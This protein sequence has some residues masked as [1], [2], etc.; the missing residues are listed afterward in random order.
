[1]DLM[2]SRTV[3]EALRVPAV[4]VGQDLRAV[5]ASPRWREAY[6]DAFTPFLAEPLSTIPGAFATARGVI[7]T[8]LEAQVVVSE[9]DLLSEVDHFE[10]RPVLARGHGRLAI[11][12]GLLVIGV[13]RAK[14][15]R[16]SILP[17]AE[18]ASEEPPE[19]TSA[20]PATV[21]HRLRTD[22]QDLVEHLGVLQASPLSRPQ[23]ERVD[24]A[25]EKALGLVAYL[26]QIEWA[27]ML[28]EAPAP[29]PAP[30][31]P[32]ARALRALVV[33]DNSINRHVAQ[34]MFGVL[35][36]DADAVGDASSAL[37]MLEAMPYDLVFMDVMLPGVDGVEVTHQIRQRY[38]PRPVVVGVTAM[39]E[40]E[41]RCRSAGMDGF[42]VKPLRLDDVSRAVA[43][44]DAV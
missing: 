16:V 10:V 1:M 23:E 19:L 3:I 40:A 7:E 14:R 25:I 38:G 32:E 41:D 36:V 34:S 29:R 33:D 22:L 31:P 27:E 11:V 4:L 44:C 21:A 18:P 2:D 13:E 12:A 39:P 6:G 30:R 5:A 35:G 17:R 42:I 26:G 20:G 28:A 37:A 15:G 24:S 8:G 43:L 9:G